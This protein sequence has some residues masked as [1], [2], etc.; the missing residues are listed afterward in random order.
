[1]VSGILMLVISVS[2]KNLGG[3]K[4]ESD[5]YSGSS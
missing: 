3:C 1:M 4:D 5:E 2:L